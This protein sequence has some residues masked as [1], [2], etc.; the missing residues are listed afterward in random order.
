MMRAIPAATVPVLLLAAVCAGC[1]C[2]VDTSNMHAVNTLAHRIDSL[3]DRLADMDTASLLHM[4]DLFTAEREGIES[5]F[6]DTLPLAEAEVLGN[7]YRAMGGT[8]PRILDDRVRLQ[9]L[10]SEASQRLEHLQHDICD[11]RIDLKGTAK[12]LAVE[13]AWCD[14]FMRDV[15]TLLTETAKLQR[16][17][18]AL[19]SAAADFL[20][21]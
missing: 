11:R 1:G 8:L 14:R 6:R 7:Y 13:N 4:R 12:A 20:R 3:K 19:R 2:A 9:G 10:L 5:R 18:V 16:D 21:Q 17:R 15:G